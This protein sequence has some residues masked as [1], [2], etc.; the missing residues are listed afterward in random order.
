MAVVKI[1]QFPDPR[2]KKVGARVVDVN[3]PEVQKMVSDMFETLYATENC[4]GLA[5][6]QLDFTEPKQITVI[7]VSEAKDTPM[8]LINPEI[9]GKQ[10]QTCE[11]EGC[12]SV[13]GGTYESVKRAESITVR[14]STPTGEV[15]ETEH[16][17]FLA[18]C[19]QH[20]IDH[21]N[22]VLFIDH[23]SSLKQMRIRKKI[24]KQK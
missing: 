23:L 3:A 5:S 6:T 2:L 15:V 11:P 7:D 22:G 8:C 9:V 16:D 19:I 4:A 21:L 1:L 12:M 10:G 17:G 20:E 24:Q 18:K 13:G 14:Y